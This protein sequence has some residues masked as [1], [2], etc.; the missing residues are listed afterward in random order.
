MF[1][2]ALLPSSVKKNRAMTTNNAAQTIEISISLDL[3]VL[4]VFPQD[5]WIQTL[6]TLLTT[7]LNKLF[8]SSAILS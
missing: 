2:D 8:I 7:L 4:I 6:L 3:G 5:S 1:S